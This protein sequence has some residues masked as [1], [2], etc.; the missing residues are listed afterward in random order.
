M[1]IIDEQISVIASFEPSYKIRPIK[2]LWGKRAFAIKEIT[3]C[4]KSSEG[5]TVIHHFSVTD[6]NTLYQISFNP[7]SLLWR[8]NSLEA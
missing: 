2:F 4:W 8:L 3:Y 1:E 6:G 5:K 7:A